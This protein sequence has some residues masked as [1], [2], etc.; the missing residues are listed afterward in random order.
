MY[1]LYFRYN[2]SHGRAKINEFLADPEEVNENVE[3]LN[4]T[5]NSTINTWDMWVFVQYVIKSG[6]GDMLTTV[7][8]NITTQVTDLSEKMNKLIDEM[9]EYDATLEMNTN[10]YM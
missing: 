5:I 7:K 10:F 9:A 8:N 4:I 2:T 3:K 1:L 6:R